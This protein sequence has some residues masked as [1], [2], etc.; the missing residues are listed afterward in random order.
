MTC[1]ILF[2]IKLKQIQKSQKSEVFSD[3]IIEGVEK[4]ESVY[5]F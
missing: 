3:K 4:G 2:K 5:T 1:K